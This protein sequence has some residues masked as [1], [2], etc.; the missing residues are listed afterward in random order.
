MRNCS[1]I[2][3]VRSSTVE[4]V[5][6]RPNLPTKDFLGPSLTSLKLQ[7]FALSSIEFVF[8]F[9]RLMTMA[10]E[11]TMTQK[12]PSA[13]PQIATIIDVDNPPPLPPLPPLLAPEPDSE[14]RAMRWIRIRVVG[15]VEDGHG[16]DEGEDDDDGDDDID[17]GVDVEETLLFRF[18]VKSEVAERSNRISEAARGV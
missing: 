10:T 12:T 14:S 3:W 5:P 11:M 2:L 8:A 4:V 17:S 15:V 6:R 7:F 16:A 9:R 1:S 18:N 13:D